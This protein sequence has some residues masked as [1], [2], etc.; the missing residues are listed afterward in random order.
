MINHIFRKYFY[1]FFVACYVFFSK[2]PKANNVKERK[3]LLFAAQSELIIA[4]QWV[5]RLAMNLQ[6]MT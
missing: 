6:A 1:V 2:L 5:R 4:K 3:I